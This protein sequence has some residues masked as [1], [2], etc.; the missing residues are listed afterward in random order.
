VQV[1]P[2]GDPVVHTRANDRRVVFEGA[3]RSLDLAAGVCERFAGIERLQQREG[4]D[5]AFER[6]DPIN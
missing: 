2:H 6:V 1:P 4:F 5:L 3:D